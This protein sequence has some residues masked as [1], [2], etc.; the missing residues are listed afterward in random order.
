MNALR[1][2]TLADFS[3]HVPNGIWVPGNPAATARIISSLKAKGFRNGVSDIVIA[4]PIGKFHGAYI[5]LKRDTKSVRRPDQIQ[6]LTL[7]RSVGYYAALAFGLDEAITRVQEF[8]LGKD[9]P[10]L[11]SA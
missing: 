6:W 3:Y 11:P 7:M 4:L 8:L 5:E 10:P 2:R 9:P 1:P